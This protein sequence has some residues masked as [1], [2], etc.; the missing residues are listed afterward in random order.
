MRRVLVA[1]CLPSSDIAF[2]DRVSRIVERDEWDLDGPAGVALLQAS[3][4]QSYPMATVTPYDGVRAGGARRTVILH[5]DRDGA[6][7]TRMLAAWWTESVYDRSGAKAYGVA[8]RLL[9]DGA[10]AEA[11]VEEAFAEIRRATLGAV[12]VDAAGDAVVAAARPLATAA[13]EARGAAPNVPTARDPLSEPALSDAS[14]QVRGVRRSLSG[15]ALSRIPSSHRAALELAVLEDLKVRQIAER[16]QTTPPTV[17]RLLKDALVAVDHGVAATAA[18]ALRR[19]RE[20]ERDW[21]RLAAGH[22]SRADRAHGVAHAWLDFQFASGAVRPGTTVLVTDADRRFVAT[23]ANAGGM[24]GRPS[25]GGLH[26]DDITAEYARPLVPDLW[27]LFDE[28]G[29]MDGAY[30]CDRPGQTPIRTT[31]RGF[32][33]RPLPELQVGYLEPLGPI[34]LGSPPRTATP[35]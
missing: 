6:E 34:S 5:V 3:L 10:A 21:R 1:A 23:S 13:R 27:A 20:T 12:G 19:W 18:T 2:G 33:A 11:A 25:A 17:H 29:A 15:T 26:I 9:G 30:D 22:P 16:M 14:L 32:W 24:L 7:A 28:N 8:A 35:T 4:R 31:F